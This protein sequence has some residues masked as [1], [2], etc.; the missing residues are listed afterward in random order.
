[1][2]LHIGSTTIRRFASADRAAVDTLLRATGN[3]CDA[4]LAIAHELMDIATTD[5][6]QDDYHAYVAVTELPNTESVI[7]FLVVGPTPATVG[8][9]DLYWIAVAPSHYGSGVAQALQQHAESLVRAR[10][11]YWLIAQ[12]SSQPSYERTQA[13]YR[14]EGYEPL[15]AFPITTLQGDDLI[16]FGKRLV[17]AAIVAPAAG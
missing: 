8:T 13:F 10:H 3:F 14:K 1:M 17:C 12:T 4:E 7:G 5:P 9:W 15:G 2:M 11:G 6:E 16:I